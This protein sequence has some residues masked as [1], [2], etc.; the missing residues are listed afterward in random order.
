[1]YVGVHLPLDIVGGAGIGTALAG[2]G[3][4]VAA[5]LG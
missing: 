1:M 2:L 4:V 3:V 5:R